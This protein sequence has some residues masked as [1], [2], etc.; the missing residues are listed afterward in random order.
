MND[1]AS[2]D[3]L[4]CMPGDTPGPV[5]TGGDSSALMSLPDLGPGH[6]TCVAWLIDEKRVEGRMRRCAYVKAALQMAQADMNAHVNGQ[7][8]DVKRVEARRDALLGQLQNEWNAAKRANADAVLSFCERVTKEA[9]S[10]FA[11]LMGLYGAQAKASRDFTRTLGYAGQLIATIHLGA[12]VT[13]KVLSL[14]PNPIGSGIDVVTDVAEEGIKAHAKTGSGTQASL[15][16]IQALGKELAKK[17]IEEAPE[18]AEL[19]MKAHGSDLTEAEVEVLERQLKTLEAKLSRRLAKYAAQRPVVKSVSRLVAQTKS[20]LLRR[21]AVLMP[22]KSVRWLA[23]KGF[24]EIVGGLFVAYE[25]TEAFN[26][27]QEQIEGFSK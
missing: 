16:E 8:A 20:V 26:E 22:L 2:P 11:T 5:G 12:T 6:C 1:A 14:I 15:A 21:R 18:I 24:S 27:W 4:M 17:G 10:D 19:L 25:V 3:A 9:D 7:G 13:R 23:K